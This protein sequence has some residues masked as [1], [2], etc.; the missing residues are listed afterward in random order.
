MLFEALP[1]ELIAD[2]LGELDLATLI[3]V[4]YLSRRLHTISSDSSLNPWR[5]PI[6]RNLHDAPEKTYE[7]ALKHLSVRHTVPRHNWLE[8]LS[9]AKAEWLLYQATLPNLKES[10]WEECFKRR[11]LPGWQKWKKESTWKETFFKLLNRAWHRSHSSCTAD[12]AWMKYIMLNRNGSANELEATSRN[13]SPVSIFNEYKLQNN[14]A[15][16][17]THTRLLV[18]FADVRI[19]ALGVLN[20]PRSNFTVNSNARTLLHP[21]GIQRDSSDVDSAEWRSVHSTASSEDHPT[22]QVPEVQPTLIGD[23]NQVYRRLTYPLPSSS[24]ANYPFFTPGGGDK[25]WFGTGESEEGGRQWVGGLMITA[26][27]IG[28]KIHEPFLE[29]PRLQ[30][31]DLIVGP[32]RTQFAS[33]TWA[34]LAAIAPWLELTKRID[35]PGLGN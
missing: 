18:E 23:L 27:L 26:Q 24:Y 15:H 28:D 10:E 29:V 5:R 31:M 8:I 16:L 19:V 6:H 30:D 17:E 13:Y 20:K 3:V 22:A 34:D 11:F 9:V 4:S 33:F 25:R 14:L 35:G 2:I 12:E 32:G 1:V 7:P 21:P